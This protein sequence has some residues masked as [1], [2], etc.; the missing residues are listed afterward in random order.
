LDFFRS[1]TVKQFKNVLP[2]FR[3]NAVA[4]LQKP[5][6]QNGITTAIGAKI[7]TSPRLRGDPNTK[8]TGLTNRNN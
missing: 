4:M 8:Q 7:P 2:A 5:K 3:S 1:E 6:L